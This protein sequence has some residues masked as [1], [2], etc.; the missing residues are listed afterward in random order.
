MRASR[1]HLPPLCLGI[2]AFQRKRWR[3]VGKR[4][5]CYIA[6]RQEP[7][8]CSTTFMQHHNSIYLQ[9]LCRVDQLSHS[10]HLASVSVT[11]VSAIHD[12]TQ[13]NSTVT[14]A[15]TDTCCPANAPLS[16]KRHGHHV[17]LELRVGRQRNVP[18]NTPP[19]A[20]RI[21]LGPSQ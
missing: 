14:C 20:L 12:I 1:L 13:P 8:S 4:R 6:S 2:R 7:C 21:P 10:R 17:C 19:S 5:A 11:L 3:L 9:G 15:S 16:A 18:A